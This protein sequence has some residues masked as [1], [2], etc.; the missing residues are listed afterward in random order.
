[1]AITHRLRIG[2]SAFNVATEGDHAQRQRRNSLRH[3]RNNIAEQQTSATHLCC[4]DDVARRTCLER[5]FTEARLRRI[6]IR[7][8]R[9]FS[10]SVIMHWSPQRRSCEPEHFVSGET[11]KDDRKSCVPQINRG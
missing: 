11:L 10:S 3:T 7:L 9:S 2:I 6:F 1:M 4:D 8:G 5:A